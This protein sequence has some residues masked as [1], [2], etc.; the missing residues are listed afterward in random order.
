MGHRAMALRR[1]TAA[2]L[3]TIARFLGLRRARRSKAQLR[4]LIEA[5]CESGI[6]AGP[7]E[8]WRCGANPSKPEQG[9]PP[10]LTPELQAAVCKLVERGNRVTAA[11][12]VHGVSPRT[13]SNWRSRGQEGEQPFADF[14]QAVER[15]YAKAEADLVE[16]IRQ[17]RSTRDFDN[18]A[19]QFLLERGRREGWGP[20]ITVKVEEAKGT[21][22]DVASEVLEP[23]AFAT[24]LQALESHG[25]GVEAE[26]GL[27]EPRAVH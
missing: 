21:L 27:P 9:G 19:L 20:S 22:L 7:V 10:E 24:L 26:P 1:M 13:L 18:R 23:K 2:E 14:V 8:C 25:A 17:G 3:Q 6:P 11:C 16:D 12:Q 15:A 5:A 4:E